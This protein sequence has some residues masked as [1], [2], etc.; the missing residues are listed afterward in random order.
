[1]V[2]PMMLF[3]SLNAC[4]LKGKNKQTLPVFWTANTKEWITFMDLFHNCFVPQ[5][6]RYLT[7][8]KLSFKVLLLWDNAPGHPEVLKVA[9]LNVEV[10][11]L[12]PNTT[13]LIHT[14]DQVVISMLK[15]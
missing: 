5:V 14:L 2:K 8:K 1:M 12:L 7:E 13:S 3:C 11:F 4:A 10:I 15:M 6:E 9:H